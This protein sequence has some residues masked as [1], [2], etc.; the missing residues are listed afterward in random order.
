MTYPRIWCRRLGP[1]PQGS[2]DRDDS[3][4]ILDFSLLR[5]LYGE[6]CPSCDRRVDFNEDGQVDIL[7]FSLLR[8]N[9]GKTGPVT[10][11]RATVGE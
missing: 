8:G 4:D 11:S 10:V 7:D 5:T 1:L 2:M 6:V 9:Y 3:V